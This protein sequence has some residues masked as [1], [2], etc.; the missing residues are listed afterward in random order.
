MA[1]K[2]VL[3]NIVICLITLIFA[4][5]SVASD[6]NTCV[7]S[8]YVK[9]GSIFKAGTDSKI[10]LELYAEDGKGVRIT[11]IEEWGG[12]M[13]QSYDYFERGNLD[14]FSGRG[15]CLNGPVCAI[16]V[17]SDGSGSHHGWDCDYIDVTTTG[18]STGCAKMKFDIGQWL[19]TDTSPYELEALRNN[20]PYD[21]LYIKTGT[22]K[23][24]PSL[25]VV[26]SS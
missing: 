19:A 13:G 17:I 23:A 16:K 9:T 1:T 25:K 2:F 26:T 3:I 6:D 8:I 10:S 4:S 22:V 12:I 5:P 18:P 15:P 24:V 7:Y 11:D 20:C 21:D 14:I